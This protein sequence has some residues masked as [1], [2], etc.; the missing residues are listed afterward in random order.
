[1]R[2]DNDSTT[3][4]TAIRELTGHHENLTDTF[5]GNDLF[6]LARFYKSRLLD[7]YVL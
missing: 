7:K 2:P 5:I 6:N 1:M 4:M 3:A